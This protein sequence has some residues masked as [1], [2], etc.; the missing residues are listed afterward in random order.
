MKEHSARTFFCCWL[1]KHLCDFGL[2]LLNLGPKD[3]ED[4]NWRVALSP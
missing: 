1:G 3:A 2:W 4:R